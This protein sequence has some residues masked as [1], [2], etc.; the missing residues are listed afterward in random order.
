MSIETKCLAIVAAMAL[1]GTAACGGGS[2]TPQADAGGAS[3]SAADLSPEVAAAAAKAKDLGLQFATSHD[4]IVAQCKNEGTLHI[5]ASTNSKDAVAPAFEKAFPYIETTWTDIS[6][7]PARER[8]LLEVEGKVTDPVD[9]AYVAPESYDEFA[10]MTDWDLYGMAES[11]ILDIPLGMINP[12]RRTVATYASTGA[13][14]AYNKDLVDESELPTSWDQLTDP[15]WSRDQ[16]GMVLAIEPKNVATLASHKDWPIDRVVELAEG[17]AKQQPIFIDRDTQ[18]ALLVQ[19]GEAAIFPFVNTQSAQREIDKNP[20][21][22]LQLHFIEPVPIRSADSAGV[23]N[24][25]FSQSPHCALLYLEWL[26]GD[27]AMAPLN[28]DLQSSFYWE[29]DNRLRKLIGDREV[30]IAE[31][32]NL[33]KLGSWMDEIFAAYGFPTVSK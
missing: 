5:Q 13:A 23:Y 18:G 24:S 4:D 1:V 17:M 11:G 6:G 33:E 25:E 7:A 16:L 10:K 9:V 26:A 27:D 21:G 14:V 30:T 32:D 31:H 15:K 29:G 19:S 8:F 20:D 3:V 2:S 22:P 12:Q 28:E